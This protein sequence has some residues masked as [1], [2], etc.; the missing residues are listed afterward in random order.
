[1]E[2][3]KDIDYLSDSAS[4]GDMESVKFFIEKCNVDVNSTDDIGRTALHKAAYRGK[5]SIVEYLLSK[6]A[7]I[8][9]KIENND[10][11][12][13]GT[14]PLT[15]AVMSGHVDTAKTLIQHG[16]D[17]DVIVNNCNL[18]GIAVMSDNPDMI[19]LVLN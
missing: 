12:L 6:G 11:E 14:T 9:S 18:L 3:D 7:N 17:A 13:S 2:S 8:N 4:I 10:P 19:D 5:D 16:A 15:W 1:M